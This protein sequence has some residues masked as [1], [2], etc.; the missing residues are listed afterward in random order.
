MAKRNRRKAFTIIELL[1]VIAIIGILVALLFPAIQAAREAAR[2]VQCQNNMKQISLAMIQYESVH[3]EV[4][5]SRLAN[6]YRS[7]V[8]WMTTVLPYMEQAPLY[9]DYDLST[10]AFDIPNQPVI[11]R[12]FELLRCPS[13]DGIGK[14]NDVNEYFG[15]R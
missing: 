11:N 12:E 9:E 15:F 8:G 10:Y 5:A 3:K 6:P 2:R 7:D 13:S 14:I 1:V 4:P